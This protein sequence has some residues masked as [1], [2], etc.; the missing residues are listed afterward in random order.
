MKKTI[1]FWITGLLLSCLSFGAWAQRAADYSFEAVNGQ[2]GDTYTA[3]ADPTA[4]CVWPEAIADGS[5]CDDYAWLPA[6]LKA[7]AD[8]TDAEAGFEIGFDFPYAGQKFN[9]FV[10]TTEGY[11]AL[12]SADMKKSDIE[13]VSRTPMA[14]HAIGVRAAGYSTSVLSPVYKSASTKIS[15]KQEADKLSVEFFSFHYGSNSTSYSVNYTVRLYKDGK[16]E[17]YFGEMKRST[18]SPSCGDIDFGIGL[19]DMDGSNY[20]KCH[21]R[22]AG[23]SYNSPNWKNTSSSTTFYGDLCPSYSIPVGTLWTFSADIPC[24]PP[25]AQVTSELSLIRPAG[26][27]LSQKVDQ[28]AAEGYAIFVSEAPLAEA[29]VPETGTVYEV[30][31]TLGSAVCVETGELSRIKASFDYTPI[32]RSKT[33]YVYTYLYNKSGKGGPAYGPRTENIVLSAPTLNAT[34]ADGKIT[35]KPE[36]EGELVVLATTEHGSMDLYDKK[37]NVGRFGI[38]TSDLAVGDEVKTAD[39]QFGGKVIFKGTAPATAF[40]YEA[41]LASF[42]SYHFAAFRFDDAGHVSAFAQ[43]DVLTDPAFP[44]SDDFKA[45]VPGIQPLGY[46]GNETF[47]VRSSNGGVEGSI[48]ASATGDAALLRLETPALTFPTEADARL[49]MDYNWVVMRNAAG[50]LA[51]EDYAGGN[52]LR[53]YITEETGETDAWTEVAAITSAN[54]DLFANSNEYKTK[55]IDLIGHRGKKCRVRIE[56]RGENL[57]SS[58]RTVIR[59]LAF[60]EKPACDAPLAIE[61]KPEM[62]YGDSLRVLWTPFNAEHTAAV[63]AYR[64]AKEDAEWQ[65]L[66]PVEGTDGEAVVFSGM[67]NRTKIVMGVRTVC[68][69]KTSAYVESAP[70][71]T[72]YQMPFVETFTEPE[73]YKNNY[74]DFYALPADWA[75]SHS[76][77]A[78]SDL[79]FVTGSET[80]AC[81]SLHDW[82]SRGSFAAGQNGC[83]RL[84]NTRGEKD[85]WIVLPPV[86]IAGPGAFLNFKA[87]LWSRET[88]AAATA[89]DIDVKAKLIVYAAPMTADNLTTQSFPTSSAVLKLEGKDALAEIG[90]GKTI[91]ATLPEGLTGKVRIGIYYT[92]GT[93]NV[94]ATYNNLYIDNIAL[95]APVAGLR[96]EAVAQT[97]ATLVWNACQGVEKYTVSVAEAGSEAEPTVKEVTEPKAV[98]TDLKPE[99]TYNVTVSYAFLGNKIGADVA[100]TTPAEA[101]VPECAVPTALAATDVTTNSAL[102][103]WE[104]AAANYQLAYKQGTEAATAWTLVPVAAKQY[105][106]KDLT[107]ETTYSVRVRAICGVGDTSAYS[108]AITF[109][110]QA[111]PVVTPCPVPTALRVEDT[112]VNSAK[113]VWDG[114]EEHQGYELRYRETAT[115][116]TDWTLVKDLAEKNY[117]LTGLKANTVYIWSVSAV[118]GEGRT[119]DWATANEFTT[120]EEVANEVALRAAFALYAAKGSLNL[121]NRDGLFVETIEVYALNGRRLLR[122]TVRT[123]DNVLLPVA[124]GNQAVIVVLQTQ[125]GRVAYKIMLP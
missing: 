88:G 4:V 120:L 78:G 8:L 34:Y 109:K 116:A 12:G 2:S 49:V 60:V 70:F 13:Y 99:T 114:V 74:G 36:G 41:A 66:K 89:D 11:I 67:P 87:A 47:K 77:Q 48:V 50:S 69:D 75:A 115:A 95:A 23:G 57:A 119:S 122:E 31:E 117:A 18:T 123:T 71:Y 80:S 68:D 14:P 32:D 124:F 17:F 52:G 65:T 103:K 125:A 92:F 76:R 85:N 46:T 10:P 111:E 63:F 1:V 81:V 3:L 56:V 37:G 59:S 42:T 84:G 5:A 38:P 19:C 105:T 73:I 108:E 102:L 27:R 82:E 55:Y 106:L 83:V 110:T 7:F 72:G 91:A 98:L 43:A 121:L 39:N 86:E 62:V 94:D 64:L 22:K 97:T 53:F 79:A 25:T 118:C 51:V 101:V 44:F 107:A 29:T 90:E 33:Y 6:G 61:V 30:G 112:A 28:T 93:A 96:A 113:L 21:Y 104:G 9:R 24:T 100:F 54:P 16:I 20:N 40:E 15:Y 35:L 45:A 26:F 58:S